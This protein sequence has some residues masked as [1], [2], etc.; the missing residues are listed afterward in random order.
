MWYAV[1]ARSGRFLVL[2]DDKEAVIQSAYAPR[3]SRGLG[4]WA[5]IPENTGSNPVR[6]TVQED[7]GWNPVPSERAGPL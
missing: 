1:R 7:A 5:F 6:G 3:W 2:A 4:R